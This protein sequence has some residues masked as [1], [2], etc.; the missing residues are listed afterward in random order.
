MEILIARLLSAGMLLAAATTALGLILLLSK[1][2]GS[3]LSL[4]FHI[5]VAQN[6][7]VLDPLDWP[8]LC[9]IGQQALAPQAEAVIKVGLLILVFTPVLRVAL[10]LLLFS[11][12]GDRL[13]VLITGAVLS[14]LVFALKN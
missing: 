8:T 10:S 3:P 11:Q 1:S 14:I 12:K 5:F 6:T 13:Y 2:G 7:D 9:R 4:N